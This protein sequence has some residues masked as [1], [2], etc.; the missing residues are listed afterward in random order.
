[1]FDIHQTRHEIEERNRIRVEAKL[2]LLSVVA[3]SRRLYEVQRKKNLEQREKEFE[4][5]FQTSPVRQ[6]LEQKLLDQGRRLREDLDW[7]PTGMLSG[8]GWA[9]YI[10]TRKIMRRIWRM[11]RWHDRGMGA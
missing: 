3:E 7:R 8:G 2:P 4:Q 9:F 1:M 6:R 5:F 10:R 11:H